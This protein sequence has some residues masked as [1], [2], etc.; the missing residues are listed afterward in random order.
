MIDIKSLE[1]ISDATSYYEDLNA[2]N[3]ELELIINSKKLAIEDLD[4]SIV[5]KNSDIDSL[6]TKKNDLEELVLLKENKIKE[7]DGRLTELNANTK[8]LEVTYQ[9]LIAN[10]ENLSA[11]ISDLT[12]EYSTKQSLLE[13]SYNNKN[14]TLKNDLNALELNKVSLEKE[15]SILKRDKGDLS[16]Q[17]QQL[18]ARLDVL[19]TNHHA[20]IAKIDDSNSIISN[21]DQE[22][23]KRHKDLEELTVKSKEKQ[24]DISNLEAKKNDLSKQIEDIN[25]TIDSKNSEL[26]D[27]MKKIKNINDKEEYLNNQEDYVAEQSL[28]RGIE[29]TPFKQ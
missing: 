19:D 3:N 16:S 26:N 10:K 4:A 2:K 6:S 9:D 25:A 24:V 21:L 13:Q 11:A 28:R 17:C 27:V 15:I 7:L 14:K 23:L 29:Y 1:Q 18:K 12:K 5:L 22:I 8:D 20:L